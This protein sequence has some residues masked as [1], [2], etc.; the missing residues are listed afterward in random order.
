M[1]R[2]LYLLYVIG[3]LCFIS[4]GLRAQ[5]ENQ[6]KQAPEF[7]FLGYLDVFYAYDFNQPESNSRQPFLYN[8]NRHNEFNINHGLIGFEVLHDKYRVSLSL[9]TGTYPIDNYSNE[10]GLLKNI[11]EAYIG[12]SLNRKNN[13]WLD[14][15]VFT[16][17]IG[18]ENPISIDNWT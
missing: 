16:S 8:H 3:I 1:R 11:Y 5:E 9:H 12:L 17:H 7:Y 10:P 15:G 4:P 2:S 14:A 13:L 18:F 6:W